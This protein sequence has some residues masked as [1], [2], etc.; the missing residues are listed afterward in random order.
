MCDDGTGAPGA[1]HAVPRPAPGAAADPVALAPV[2]EV[3]VSVLVD[4]FYDAL[5]AD[6]A[7]TRRAGFS[8][9][10]APGAVAGGRRLRDQGVRPGLR[11]GDRTRR[12]M[13]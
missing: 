7:R 1:G 5:L 6:D 4:D 10:T 11:T 2:D 9:G 13:R 8:V 12:S 3:R